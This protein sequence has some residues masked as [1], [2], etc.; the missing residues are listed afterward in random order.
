MA[1]CNDT[2]QYYRY[3]SL[4]SLAEYHGTGGPLIVQNN[5]IRTPLMSGFLKAGEYLGYPVRDPNG[6]VQSGIIG[7]QCVNISPR[8]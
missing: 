5:G 2:I 8:T 3:R 4:I 1:V 7:I 6:A